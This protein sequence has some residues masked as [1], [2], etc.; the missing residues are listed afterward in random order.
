M[1]SEVYS[2]TEA[3]ALLKADKNLVGYLVQDRGI[4]YRVKG[5]C[6][7]I[8]EEGLRL[9]GWELAAYEAKVART[10]S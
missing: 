7:L 9:L 4:P 1:N 6:K 10:V 8:D 3:A 5:R 2:L